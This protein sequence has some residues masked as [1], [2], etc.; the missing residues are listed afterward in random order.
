VKLKPW[1]IISS[2][3]NYMLARNLQVGL[4]TACGL[5]AWVA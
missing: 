1:F 3:L 2:T 4:C 5:A